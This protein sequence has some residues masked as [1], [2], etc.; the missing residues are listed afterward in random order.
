MQGL[1][2]IYVDGEFQKKMIPANVGWLS[3]ENA[4]NLLDYKMELKTSVNVSGEDFLNSF[5][6]HA[7]KYIVLNYLESLA[8]EILNPRFYHIFINKA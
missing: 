4:W 1:A 3:V 8:L 6:I 2:F 7:F 5:G